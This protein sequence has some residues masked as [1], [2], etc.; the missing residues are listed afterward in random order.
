MSTSTY[1][2]AA[3]FGLCIIAVLRPAKG[4][5]FLNK[6]SKVGMPVLPNGFV[7]YSQVPKTGAF[8]ETTIPKGL[9]KHHNTK[10]GTWGIINVQSGKLSYSIEEGSHKGVY[11]LDVTRKGIIEPTILHSVAPVPGDAVSFVVEFYRLP[12]TGPVDEKR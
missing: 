8:T 6:E 4:F 2:S 10:A 5:S 1:L 12:G 11:P 7:K 9:L 3:L